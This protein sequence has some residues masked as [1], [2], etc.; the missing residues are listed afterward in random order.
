MDID[1]TFCNDIDDDEGRFPNKTHS[2]IPTL[3]SKHSLRPIPQ[4]STE[5]SK[6]PEKDKNK[7][8]GEGKGGRPTLYYEKTDE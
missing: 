3:I 5:E 2:S 1:D 8:T 6:Y 4:K 7:K